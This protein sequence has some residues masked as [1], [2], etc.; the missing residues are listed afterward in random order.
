MNTTVYD[1]IFRKR[2]QNEKNIVFE[3]PLYSIKSIKRICFQ[4]LTTSTLYQADN[5]T[6]IKL[7]ELLYR[8]A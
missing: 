3:V 5:Q 7:K 2:K 4:E 8:L 1:S 6:V